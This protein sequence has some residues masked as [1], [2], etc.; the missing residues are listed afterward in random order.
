M[1]L[2]AALWPALLKNKR[3]QGDEG[4]RKRAEQSVCPGG[5]EDQVETSCAN[6]EDQVY[7]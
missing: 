1:W 3:G 4:K 5:N 2:P 6:L 7:G